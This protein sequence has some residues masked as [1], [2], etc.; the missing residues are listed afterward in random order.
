V[1]GNTFNGHSSAACLQ[2]FGSQF[3][4]VASSNVTISGNTFQ[5]CGDT[6]A[7]WN[8][9]IQLSQ[10]ITGISITDNTIDNAYQAV[11]TR[12]G[13]GWDFDGKDIH[14]N[15]NLVTNTRNLVVNNAVTGNMDASNNWWG[16]TTTPS[17]MVV[18]DVTF[19]PW[20]VNSAKT[21]LSNVVPTVTLNGDAEMTVNFPATYVEQG[22]TAVDSLGNSLTVTTDGTVNDKKG[23]TYVV[24][25]SATDGNGNTAQ[26]TRTVV[27]PNIQ[28]SSSGSSRGGG[29]GGNTSFAATVVAQT[30]AA[31]ASVLPGLVLGAETVSPEIQAQINVVKAQISVLIRQ[32]IAILHQEIPTPHKKPLA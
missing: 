21:I 19:D 26:A 28:S 7:P 22:A 24:T 16:S 32:L 5:D 23:G 10:E 3:N 12:V 2:L 15:S 4:L 14:F 25:Y 11:N 27:V 18:G 6:V 1:T 20:Y 8:Y 31:T 30:P 29:G 13:D 9:A 17:A